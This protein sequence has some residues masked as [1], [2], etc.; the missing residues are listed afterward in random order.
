MSTDSHLTITCVNQ[1]GSIRH[2]DSLIEKVREQVADIRSRS[3]LDLTTLEAITIAEDLDSA[4]ARF[5]PGPVTNSRSLTRT[6]GAN[7]GFG[8]TVVCLRAGAVRSHIF[9]SDK[10]LAPLMGGDYQRQTTAKYLLAHEACHAHDTTIRAKA[11]GIHVASPAP[12]AL[13]PGYIWALMDV[14]W[15]EYV[16][17]R[18][19]AHYCPTMRG[20]MHE[21]LRDTVIRFKAELR[22]MISECKKAGT[23]APS[24]GLAL[25]ALYGIIKYSAY[26]QGHDDA[27]GAQERDPE[28]EAGLG[29]AGLSHFFEQLHETLREMWSRY[30]DWQSAEVYSQLR[31]SVLNGLRCCCLDVYEQ[32]G[33]LMSR[34]DLNSISILSL[35]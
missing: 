23:S 8:M 27:I 17:C 29:S 35:A 34:L 5:D 31:R 4:L 32:N 28:L 2:E 18:L 24:T 16:A 3:Q 1:D 30:P 25:T 9:L 11:L 21:M 20:V 7:E 12:D 33:T 19:S 10:A 22:H 15:D 6:T 26:V 14:A 13:T